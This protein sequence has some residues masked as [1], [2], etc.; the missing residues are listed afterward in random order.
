V[1]VVTG[2]TAALLLLPAAC[3]A[4]IVAVL[5]RL[6]FAPPLVPPYA[7]AGDAP[8]EV[9]LRPGATFEVVAKPSSPPGGIV[10]AKGFLLRAG[11]NRPWDAPYETAVDGTVRIGGPVETVFK[12]VPAGAW[13]VA[14][15]VGRPELLPSMPA[16]VE[17]ARDESAPSA[18]HV[19]HRHVMLAAR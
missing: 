7:L 4:A 11:E 8:A 15:V 10:G 18:F 5:L 16:D 6:H 17:R 19:L 14:V 13:D 3:I 2:R 9:V 12:G 1:S